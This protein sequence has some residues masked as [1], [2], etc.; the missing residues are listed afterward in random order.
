LGLIDGRK[1][2]AKEM[3]EELGLPVDSSNRFSNLEMPK[4]EAAKAPIKHKVAMRLFRA[5]SCEERGAVLVLHQGSSR[6]DQ[7]QDRIAHR[8]LFE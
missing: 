2:A 7:R 4:V 5:R 3:S 1:A 8:R 6:C